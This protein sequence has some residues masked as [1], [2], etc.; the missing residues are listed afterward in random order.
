M[1]I[2]HYILLFITLMMVVEAL[3]SSFQGKTNSLSKRSP[4]KQVAATQA[5]PKGAVE[6]QEGEEEE[7]EEQAPVKIVPNEKAKVHLRTM[8]E[9]LVGLVNELRDNGKIRLPDPLERVFKTIIESVDTVQDDLN[10]DLN[11][12]LGNLLNSGGK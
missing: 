2:I 6:E 7:K 10:V 3:P 1:K 5:A 4:A 11:M 9:S 12:D 8:V